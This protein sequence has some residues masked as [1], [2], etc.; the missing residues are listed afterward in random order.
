MKGDEQTMKKNYVSPEVMCVL[1]AEEDIIR[2][3]TEINKDQELNA[4]DC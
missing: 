3:S 4:G 1:L 2:T